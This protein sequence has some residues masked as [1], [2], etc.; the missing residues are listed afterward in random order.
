MSG[1]GQSPM[2][3]LSHDSNTS[4]SNPGNHYGEGQGLEPSPEKPVTTPRTPTERKR[5]RKTNASGPTLIAT[6]GGGGGGDRGGPGSAPLPDIS[7]AQKSSN[8]PISEYF[9]KRTPSS[10]V[11]G[12]TKSPLSFG[13]M[14]PQSPKTS[15]VSSPSGNTNNG[16]MSYNQSDYYQQHSQQ[17]N[18]FIQG[19]GP[20]RNFTLGGGSEC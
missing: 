2:A 19:R 20:V 3:L 12:G 11:R 8:K 18:Y 9:P 10:P 16:P 14:Y 6:P 5:K 7:E 15:Y 17:G 4:G 1:L 13:S